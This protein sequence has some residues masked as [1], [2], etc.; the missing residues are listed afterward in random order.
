MQTAL[1]P[2]EW[3]FAWVCVSGGKVAFR[4]GLLLKALSPTL[5]ALAASTNSPNTSHPQQP[6]F[7]AQAPGDPSHAVATTDELHAYSPTL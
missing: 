4:L 3:E 1:E 7:G 6:D 2:S 5:R